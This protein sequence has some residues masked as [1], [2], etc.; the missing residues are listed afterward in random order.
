MNIV[1]ATNLIV[2]SLKRNWFRGVTNKSAKKAILSP[3]KIRANAKK[4]SRHNTIKMAGKI[5]QRESR[6]IPVSIF[7]SFIRVKL[8]GK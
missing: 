4:D 1:Y 2:G 7:I 3:N 5:N 8:C 6:F